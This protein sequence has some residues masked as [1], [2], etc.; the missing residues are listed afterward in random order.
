MENETNSNP[1]NIE[2]NLSSLLTSPQPRKDFVDDLAMRLHF[3]YLEHRSFRGED[4]PKQEHWFLSFWR[5]LQTR[6]VL[7]VLS[8]LIA[9]ILLTGIVY[10]VGQ[11]SGYIPGFGFTSSSERIYVLEE[12]ITREENGLIF[13]VEQAVSDK[14]RFWVKVR[15]ENLDEFP[16]FSST[17]LRLADGTQIE[18]E[19]SGSNYQDGP[20]TLTY[21]FKPLPMDTTNLTLFFEGINEG[22]IEIPLGL[23]SIQAGEILPVTELGEYPILSPSL[24]GLYL[25]LDHVAPGSDRTVFQVSVQFDEPDTMIIGPWTVTLQ[26]QE[27]HVYPL[28][29]IP[30]NNFDRGKSALFQTIPFTGNEELILNL[31]SVPIAGQKISLMK[32]YSSNPGKF[33]FDPG[34]NPQPGQVWVMDEKVQVGEFPVNVIRAELNNAN[35]LNFEIEALDDV[36]GVMLYADVPEIKSARGGVPTGEDY[37]TSAIGFEQLPT[38]PIEIQIRSLYLS[39]AGEWKI[40]WTPPA[41]LD[42]SS[43]QALPTSTVPVFPTATATIP[44][45]DALY[46]EVKRL[47]DQF[48]APFQQGP[49]W[50]YIVTEQHSKVDEGQLLPPPYLKSNEWYEIDA[51]GYVQRSLYTEVD[52]IGTILQQVASI[53]NYSI[54]FTF[55]GGGYNETGLWRL[56][57]DR[58]SESFLRAEQDKSEISRE[59]V[60]CQDGKRCLLISVQNTFEQQLKLFGNEKAIT[61]TI[62]KVWIDKETGLQ[63]KIESVYRYDDGSEDVRST[64]QVLVVEK[65]DQV[66]EEIIVILDRVVLP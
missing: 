27:G 44:S 45:E 32:D 25:S 55:G 29:E 40:Y 38:D 37:F 59:E 50:I 62:Y 52:E 54:N 65:V 41:A 21:T 23:R 1:I 31:Q 19:S 24:H 61:A 3:Q 7:L 16:F 33:V 18:L 48:D 22:I 28:T 36:T 12:V 60:D 66:P 51:D 46:L 49:G 14:E 42:E 4:S 5:K 34:S 9:M 63:F 2:V 11:L 39:L 20:T 43:V 6:P 8:V 64:R 13:R 17:Y 53:G 26:D 56:S 15:V 57:L 35:E 30:S 47:S 10:A 58:L